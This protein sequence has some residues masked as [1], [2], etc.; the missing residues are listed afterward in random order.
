VEDEILSL[1]D[2]DTGQSVV[3][4]FKSGNVPRQRIPQGTWDILGHPDPNFYRLEAQDIPYG[5]DIHNGTGRD[6]FRVHHL[7]SGANQGCIAAQNGGVWQQAKAL[8]D[9]TSKGSR[10]VLRNTGSPL[11]GA[12]PTESVSYYGEIDIEDSCR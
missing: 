4:T 2:V 3:G 10:E 8:L 9:A 5:D 1:V 12:F 6:L 7:G 11:A